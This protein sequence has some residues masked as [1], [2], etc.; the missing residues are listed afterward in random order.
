MEHLLTSNKFSTAPDLLLI[1]LGLSA[2]TSVSLLVIPRRMKYFAKKSVQILY[3]IGVILFVA[4]TV[5]ALLQSTQ[6]R[7]EG[8]TLGVWF[9]WLFVLAIQTVFVLMMN[10]C[11]D[12]PKPLMRPAT[13]MYR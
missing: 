8:G 7:P 11:V 4:W 1:Y 9:A 12:A 5:F 3:G 6:F 10:D 2:I 13:T